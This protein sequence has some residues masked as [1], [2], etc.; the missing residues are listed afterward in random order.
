VSAA[1]LKVEFLYLSNDKRDQTVTFEEFFQIIDEQISSQAEVDHKRLTR[2]AQAFE[3]K[4]G[5]RVQWN[6]FLKAY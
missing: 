2:L 4:S 5:T 6:E 3:T 1:S